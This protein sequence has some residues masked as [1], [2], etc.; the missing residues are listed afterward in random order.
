MG[1]R[2]CDTRDDWF[3]DD[4]LD[5]VSE[6]DDLPSDGWHLAEIVGANEVES[7]DPTK[8]DYARRVDFEICGG[9][10]DGARFGRV[11]CLRARDGDVRARASR[12]V[13]RLIQA[14]KGSGP[15]PRGFT[16][17]IGQAVAVKTRQVEYEVGGIG[18][19]TRVILLDVASP[20]TVD[21]VGGNK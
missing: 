9:D 6:L 18:K 20:A 4:L 12:A 8:G 2:A 19:K 1:A 5:L 14:A 10:S 11:Y 13:A 3:G 21:S 16:D 17:L 7:F 15:W